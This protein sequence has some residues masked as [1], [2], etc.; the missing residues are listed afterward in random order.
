MEW[1][2]KQFAVCSLQF[3][4]CGQKYNQPLLQHLSAKAASYFVP[5]KSKRTAKI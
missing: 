4:V 2:C 3:A 5:F 1:H